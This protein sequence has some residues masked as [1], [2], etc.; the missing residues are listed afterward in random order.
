MNMLS[1]ISLAPMIQP[2]VG[3]AADLEHLGDQIAELSA[4]LDAAGA[5]LLD[6]IREFDARGGGS[7]WTAAPPVSGSASRGPSARCR[8]W[9]RPSRVGSCRI[10]R[11][12]RSPVSPP[13][14]PKS[15]CSG[16]GRP[17][18]PSTSSESFAAG[19]GSIDRPKRGRRRGA[20][21]A[22]GCMCIRTKTVWSSSAG[23]SRRRLAPCLFRR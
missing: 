9:P 13:R 20:T 8:C 1:D 22:A 7:G 5:R 14:K 4:H 3:S 23:G 18:P 12:A 16:S 10:R 21:P 15:G 6:L 2:T 11:S 19:A 17:A